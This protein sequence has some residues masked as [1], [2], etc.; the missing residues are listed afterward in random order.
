MPYETIM[1][2]YNPETV[3]TDNDECYRLYFD[4]LTFEVKIPILIIARI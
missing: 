3:S 1:V 2:N 4:K